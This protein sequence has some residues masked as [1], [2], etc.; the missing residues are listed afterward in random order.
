M[1]S[2]STGAVPESRIDAVLH[3]VFGTSGAVDSASYL[4]TFYQQLV[5]GSQ[6]RYH[7]LCAVCRDLCTCGLLVVCV[8]AWLVAGLD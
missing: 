1:P 2:K 7:T 8:C 3:R 4:K 6:V 5:L